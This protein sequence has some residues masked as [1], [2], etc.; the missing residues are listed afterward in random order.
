MRSKQFGFCLYVPETDISY[1]MINYQRLPRGFPGGAGVKEP[2]DN[3]GDAGW[4][5]GSGR[6]PGGGHS[7]PFQYCCLENPIDRRAWLQ[8]IRLQRVRHD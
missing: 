1:H 6:S 2:P 5:P 4:I 3:A 7:N 8:S